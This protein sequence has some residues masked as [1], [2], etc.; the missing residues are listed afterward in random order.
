MQSHIKRMVC[1]GRGR[2]RLWGYYYFSHVCCS[3]GLTD[4][5]QCIR[6]GT[7]ITACKGTSGACLTLQD[8][9]VG[10]DINDARQDPSRVESGSTH[11]QIKFAYRNAHAIDPEVSQAQ[12]TAAHWPDKT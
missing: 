4:P 11:V 8:R 9:V 3:S 10:A 7:R 12:D 5:W 1:T 6:L 2:G